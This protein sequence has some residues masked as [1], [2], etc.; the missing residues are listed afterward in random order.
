MKILCLFDGLINC[1]PRQDRS[2]KMNEDNKNNE[3]FSPEIIDI[4]DIS[5]K[6]I[7][8]ISCDITDDVTP[9]FY[10]SKHPWACQCYSISFSN[11]TWTLYTTNTVIDQPLVT[12]WPIGCI[13]FNYCRKMLSAVRHYCG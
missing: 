7:A 1:Y 2:R 12:N 10:D 6:M 13:N 4:I 9:C 5:D 3:R 11:N 8:D